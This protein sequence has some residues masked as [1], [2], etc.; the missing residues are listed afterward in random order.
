MRA[1]RTG[2][3]LPRSRR[4]KALVGHWRA[5]LPCPYRLEAVLSDLRGV[6]PEQYVATDTRSGLEVAVTGDFPEHPDDRVRIARTC[7]LFTRLV[8]TILGKSEAERRHGFRAVEI[9]LELADALIQQNM[10]EV[11][12]LVRETMQTM[13]ITN[14]QLDD[15]AR[16]LQALGFEPGLQGSDAADGAPASEA[17]PVIDVPA[18]DLPPADSPPDH[19]SPGDRQDDQRGSDQEPPVASS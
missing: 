4:I 11:Q 7:T 5:A 10:D 12:R 1:P 8:A 18:A 16:Q 15:L 14:A 9:Q 2:R 6:M 17:G 3:G 13:G 19:E